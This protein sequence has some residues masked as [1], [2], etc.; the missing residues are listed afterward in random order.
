MVRLFGAVIVFLVATGSPWGVGTAAA[1]TV[2]VHG[3]ITE[4]GGP[5]KLGQS[6]YGVLRYDET[7]RPDPIAGDPDRVDDDTATLRLVCG[8]VVLVAEG[9]LTLTVEGDGAVSRLVVR[10]RRGWHVTAGESDSQADLVIGFIPGT[11]SS[12]A[13]NLPGPASF[14]QFWA[15]GSSATFQIGGE[16][17]DR[18]VGALHSASVV[19]TPLGA[20]TGVSL[21]ASAAVALLLHRRRRRRR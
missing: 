21:L 1:L 10:A 7:R 5:L 16:T 6:F 12:S 2:R 13:A 18:A 19:P 17:G 3:V 11:R 9:G 4:A 20:A 14:A 8:E 15:D